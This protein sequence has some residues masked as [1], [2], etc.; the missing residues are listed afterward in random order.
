ML[1][2]LKVSQDD[3]LANKYGIRSGVG[4]AAPQIGLNKC[5]FPFLEYS[6]TIV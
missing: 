5:M 4:L 6:T 2:Y 3:E 1:E